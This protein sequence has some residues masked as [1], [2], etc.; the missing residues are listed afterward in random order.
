MI[1]FSSVMLRVNTNSLENTDT[2]YN[3]KFAI[4]GTSLANSI[5]EE[6]SDKA[7][8]ENTVDNSITD[9]TYLTPPS[10]L[11]REDGEVYPHFNDVDDFNGYTRTDS[12]M[13]SAVFHLICKVEYVSTL[14]PDVVS[15]SCTWSK[16]ITVSVY[17]SSMSDT[18]KLSSLYTYWTFR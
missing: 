8:D 12:T 17:S 10:S 5:I 4:L 14:N 6:A 9:S 18:L 7:F 13:P 15:S 2:V 3:S 11:G 16:R 1:L